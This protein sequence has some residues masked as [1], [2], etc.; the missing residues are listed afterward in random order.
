VP[1]KRH[2]LE[3]ESEYDDQDENTDKENEKDS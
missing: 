3:D 1:Q 2:D